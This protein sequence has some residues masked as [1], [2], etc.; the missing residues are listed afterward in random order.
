[1]SRLR[2]EKFRDPLSTAFA[3]HPPLSH[4][5]STSLYTDLPNAAL[6]TLFRATSPSQPVSNNLETSPRARN[7]EAEISFLINRTARSLYRTRYV[8]KISSRATGPKEGKRKLRE[9]EGS[10]LG[11]FSAA[12][13]VWQFLQCLSMRITVQNERT[14]E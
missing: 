1:M 12:S 6:E 5:P 10:D 11:G 2:N 14:N 8:R 9:S 3:G 13:C 4:E 7:R